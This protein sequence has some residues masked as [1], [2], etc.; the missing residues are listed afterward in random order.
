MKSNSRTAWQQSTVAI[1]ISLKQKSLNELKLYVRIYCCVGENS[2]PINQNHFEEDN[3]RSLDEQTKIAP[4]FHHFDFENSEVRFQ[5]YFHRVAFDVNDGK[6]AVLLTVRRRPSPSPS[7]P[8]N[9]SSFAGKFSNNTSFHSSMCSP[10][11]SYTVG[12]A[13][14]FGTGT[15]FQPAR[16]RTIAKV[17]R[18]RNTCF[19]KSEAGSP[20]D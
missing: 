15:R 19:C 17:L 16:Q 4:T 13:A 5:L 14:D 2:L 18:Y 10:S 11:S 20:S 7:R 3:A 6:K 9:Y 1:S 8:L 12:T